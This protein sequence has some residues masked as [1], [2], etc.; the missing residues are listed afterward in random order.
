MF[1]RGELE[2]KQVERCIVAM[3]ARMSEALALC[4]DLSTTQAPIV[5][6][7]DNNAYTHST[8]DL[9]DLLGSA[10]CIINVIPAAPDRVEL[11]RS[12]DGELRTDVTMQRLRVACVFAA[13]LNPP[14]V[15]RYGRLLDA[16]EVAYLMASIY[17]DALIWCLLKYAPDGVAI[18]EAFVASSFADTTIL[19]TVGRV[20]RAVVD[21]DFRAVG[22]VPIA[23][24][25]VANPSP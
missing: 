7:P 23:Q 1:R 5:V 20:G 3:Q 13:G 18:S 2:R 22:I 12:G 19:D 15:R 9:T 16:D 24:Y 14:E 4:D 11:I 17:K 6:A 8:R 25:Q 10:G 21:I